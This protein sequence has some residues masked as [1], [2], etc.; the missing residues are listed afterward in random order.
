ME[1]LRSIGDGIF[2]IVGIFSLLT[3][4]S[5]VIITF[6]LV[7]SG[8]EGKELPYVEA[9]LFSTAVTYFFIRFS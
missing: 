7:K 4:I 8:T 1:M 3:W 5:K 6:A 2:M 9:F